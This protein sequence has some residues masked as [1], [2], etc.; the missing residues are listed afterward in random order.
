MA[1]TVAVVAIVVLLIERGR[2]RSALRRLT[3][4]IDRWISHDEYDH[5]PIRGPRAQSNL[6]AAVDRL[7]AS[8]HDRGEELARERPWRQELVDSLIDPAL[9]F[10]SEGR[11]VTANEAARALFAIPAAMVDLTVVQAVGS[12]SIS[13]A[14]H[15]VRH[16]SEAVTVDVERGDRDLR[17]IV[18]Q[19]GDETWVLVTDRTRER[20]VEELRRNFVVNASHE[21][22]TPV[23]AIQT[24]GE[25]LAV[26]AERDPERTRELIGR[27]QQETERLA[28][29]VYDLLDLRRLEER[30]PLEL[31]TVDLAEVTRRVALAEL[32]HAAACDV[33][34]AV[35]VPDRAL[36]AGVPGDL[37][38]VVKNLVANAIQY[39]GPGGLVEVR[40]ASGEG[41]VASA[42]NAAEGGA[43]APD[44]SGDATSPGRATSSAHVSGGSDGRAMTASSA[45]GDEASS[46]ILT[47]RDT[48][49]GIPQ[50]DLERVF[51]RFY[52][53]DTARSRDTGGTG[54]GLSIVRHAVERHGGAIAVRSEVGNG[55]VF[56]VT[57]PRKS[58]G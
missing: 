51:E 44:T 9:L 56:T 15:Q 11:L 30:G 22:K 33:D 47:V 35:D 49:I 32:D 50:Q 13:E 45:G 26:T 41:S 19:V 17:V 23:T 55:T 12:A 20:A 7:G 57:L 4:E 36:V 54:L 38:V 53:V 42:R 43:T 14:V 24:L 48:G 31:E 1:L 3:A 58:N 5:M 40:I 8:H 6:V 37:E 25:A 46:L 29:L 34:L 21:L 27:L 18:S 2:E 16:G 10:S 52:R 39:N 28:R